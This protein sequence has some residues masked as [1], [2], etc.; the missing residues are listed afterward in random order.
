MASGAISQASDF[1][2][3]LEREHGGGISR[4]V[5]TLVSLN[6]QNVQR[7]YHDANGNQRNISTSLGSLIFPL[8]GTFGFN[9]SSLSDQRAP[10]P[11]NQ[12]DDLREVK[13]IQEDYEYNQETQEMEPPK[14][15]ICIYEI[16]GPTI[17][18]P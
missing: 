9:N 2:N 13:I 8:I 14:C 1:F 5:A 6:N 12:I 11:E 4:L 3:R 16:L 17:K 18:T 7:Q 10:V 15:S